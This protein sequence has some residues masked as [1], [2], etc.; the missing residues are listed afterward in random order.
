MKKLLSAAFLAGW[1]GPAAAQIPPL[2]LYPTTANEILA[3][4]CG[5]AGM[6]LWRAICSSDMMAVFATANNWTT[7]QTFSGGLSALLPWVQPSNVALD[8]NRAVI[9]SFPLTSEFGANTSSVVQALVGAV[10]VPSTATGTLMS[11]VSGYSRTAST[12]SDAVGI[13]GEGEANAA[14]VSIWGGNV[15][16]SNAPGFALN[17]GTGFDLTSL[18]GLEIDTAVSKK[19][20]NV[21]PN[22]PI[23]GLWI[24]GSA[25]A[26]TTNTIDDAIDVGY[27]GVGNNVPWKDAIR[28]R[29]GASNVAAIEVDQA[30]TGNSQNSQYLIFSSTDAGGTGHINTIYGDNSL[31]S[32]ILANSPGSCTVVTNGVGGGVT[33]W[34]CYNQVRALQP[35]LFSQLQDQSSSPTISSCGTSPAMSSGSTNSNGQFTIGTGTPAACTVTFST[36]WPNNAFCTVSPANSA[37][38]AITGG[39]YISASSKTGFTLMLGTGTSSAVFNYLCSGR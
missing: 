28:I 38:A 1:L 31:G 29:T 7:L 8:P 15:V 12:A 3:T 20:G 5:S 13:F 18:I 37:A 6:P 14:N 24:T 11:G 30:G 17:D 39:Y 25:T 16:A 19:S 35:F 4:P 21:I 32:L 2:T 33:F 22:I 27:A 10:D 34:S 9:N 26:Q 36:A 23:M